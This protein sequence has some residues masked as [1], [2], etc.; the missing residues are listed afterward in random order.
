VNGEG[1]KLARS[2]EMGGRHEQAKG[3]PTKTLD[4]AKPHPFPAQKYP[5]FKACWNFTKLWGIIINIIIQKRSKKLCFLSQRCDFF[6][7]NPNLHT[8]LSKRLGIA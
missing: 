2:I 3:S 6:R 8:H 7:H 4:E 5:A 1:S